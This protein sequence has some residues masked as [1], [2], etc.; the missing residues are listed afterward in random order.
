M[1]LALPR[2]EWSREQEDILRLEYE[3]KEHEEKRRYI[4]VGKK[5]QARF[6]EDDE[7]YEAE[8]L[9]ETKVGVHVSEGNLKATPL[10]RQSRDQ[11]GAARAGRIQRERERARA[12]VH[13]TCAGCAD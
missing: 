6:Y 10:R 5:V 13:Q 7:T 11:R 9:A 12:R 4:K 8:I 3:K 2:G 1:T